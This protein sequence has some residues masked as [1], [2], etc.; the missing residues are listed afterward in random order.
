[1]L[2]TLQIHLYDL[3]QRAAMKQTQDLR[4]DEAGRDRSDERGANCFS[5][6]QGHPTTIKFAVGHNFLVSVAVNNLLANLVIRP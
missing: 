3:M 6:Q 2:D 4:Q 5:G 1:M